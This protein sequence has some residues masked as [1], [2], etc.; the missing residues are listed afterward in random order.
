MFFKKIFLMLPLFVLSNTY[1]YSHMNKV[2]HSAI[3]Y[4]HMRKDKSKQSSKIC[5]PKS[6][7]LGYLPKSINQQKYVDV[8]D[9]SCVKMVIATGPAGTGKTLFACLKA[10]DLLNKGEIHKIIITRPLVTVEEDL[11]FLPGNIVKKMDPWTR[12]IFDLFLEY[13]SRSELDNLINNDAIEI[14][15]IAF[16]RGR[17]FKNSFIIA[18]EMQN[19]TP[20]QMKMLTTRI[21]INSKIVITGD[22]QQS[23]RMVDNGLNDIMN[24]M[25]TYTN[26]NK[27][28]EPIIETIQLDTYDIERSELVKEMINIYNY[29]DMNPTRKTVDK[30]D[31]TKDK[32]KDKIV[33]NITDETIINLKVKP[34]GKREI[35]PIDFDALYKRDV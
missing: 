10:I 5:K 23:D 2:Y 4:L 35:K 16:M 8:L 26:N 33:G 22:L 24:K 7:N 12:P 21:G 28:E 27:V 20:N 19:S 31:K 15:P 17:T 34:I 25:N 14:S 3:R 29:K 13:Y 18:D 9:K 11:G 30:K 32:T 6:M 1:K